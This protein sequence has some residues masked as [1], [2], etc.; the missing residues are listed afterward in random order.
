MIFSKQEIIVFFNV[1]G[2]TTFD[3]W[4]VISHVFRGLS[5]IKI[6]MTLYD[7][8]DTVYLS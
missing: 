1:R 7:Y 6:I 4:Q 8:T 3:L 5:L 2:L